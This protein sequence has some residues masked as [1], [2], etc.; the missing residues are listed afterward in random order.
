MFVSHTSTGGKGAINVLPAT[1]LELAALQSP[2][3]YEKRGEEE[4]EKAAGEWGSV[5]DREGERGSERGKGGVPDPFLEPFCCFCW[6]KVREGEISR[7]R[8]KG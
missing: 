3:Q 2:P 7:E 8:G 1:G 6:H 4:E 5:K